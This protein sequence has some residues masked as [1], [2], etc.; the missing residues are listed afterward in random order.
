MVGEGSYTVDLATSREDFRKRVEEINFYAQN[1]H[2]QKG[3][4]F[5]IQQNGDFLYCD[6][7]LDLN[8]LDLE[9]DTFSHNRLIVF[10]QKV[11]QT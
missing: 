5:N 10:N 8:P 1:E 6:V 9:N 4:S 11:N 7:P 3:I 2:S